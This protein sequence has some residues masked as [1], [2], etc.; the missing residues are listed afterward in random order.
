MGSQFASMQSPYS[1]AQQGKGQGLP[2]PDAQ[3]SPNQPR[4]D[5]QQEM[6]RR[7]PQQP[8]QQM[9]MP[10]G[11]PNVEPSVGASGLDAM[12]NKMQNMQGQMSQGKG[13]SQ[14]PMNAAMYAI[15]AMHGRPTQDMQQPQGA[16][17]AITFPGQGGQPA[18]GQPNAY[19]NT[20]NPSDN[21]GMKQM[22]TNRQ[23]KGKG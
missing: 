15:N 22:S 19:P 7:F 23:G 20:I 16:Q 21:T 3:M 17:G 10:M 12:A 13:T 1:S 11:A 14:G 18:M 6:M 9:D 4:M 5:A 8:A 2:N